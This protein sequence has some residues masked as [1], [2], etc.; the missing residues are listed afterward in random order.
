MNSNLKIAAYSILAILTMLAFISAFWLG[1]EN[2]RVYSDYME[3]QALWR[4]K[5]R[6]LEF[7][8]DKFK[9]EIAEIRSKLSSYREQIA[10]LED[11]KVIAEEE[12]QSLASENT[13]LK[14]EVTRLVRDKG[15]LQERLQKSTKRDERREDEFWSN[16]LREKSALELQMSNLERLLQRKDQEISRF[17]DEGR[18]L[19]QITG[20][21]LEEKSLLEDR[22]GET[23]SLVS[24]FSQSLEQEREERFESIKTLEKLEQD[25]QFLALQ[26]EQAQQD[27]LAAE[28]RLDNLKGKMAQE[29]EMKSRF[30]KRVGY[31]NQILE[32]KML[33]VTRLKQDLETALEDIKNMAY[34]Q[35]DSRVE[36]PPIEIRD[37]SIRAKVISVNNS[38]GFIVIDRGK[39]DGVEKGMESFIYREGR[40]IAKLMVKEVREVTSALDILLNPPND[41]IVKNDI[42]EFSSN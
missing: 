10:K 12:L 6:D 11:R 5:N 27:K 8:L 31:V 13:R 18:R 23:K 19:N 2:R 25:K 3:E 30:E 24:S 14:N 21:L 1:A 37:S 28:K 32:D 20:E 26:L 36:L 16:L 41:S 22:L 7:E 42:V 17:E 35:E 15:S 40:L 33:E 34:D 9:I 29:Q 38:E 39:R 4:Q